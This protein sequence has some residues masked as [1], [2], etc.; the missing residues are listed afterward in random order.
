E[1]IADTTESTDEPIVTT[2]NGV[3]VAI[4]EVKTE[5]KETWGRIKGVSYTIKNMEDGTVEPDYFLLLVEGYGDIEKKIPLSSGSKS[6]KSK[7]SAS[8]YAIVP[9]GF[10]YSSVTTG[11]LSSVGITLQLYDAAGKLI[12]ATNKMVNLEG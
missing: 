10:S 1:E 6:I 12:T 8:S 4:G 2:Y 7:T 5:W 3:S 11:D 9:G